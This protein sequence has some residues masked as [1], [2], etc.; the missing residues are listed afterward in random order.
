MINSVEAVGRFQKIVFGITMA[1]LSASVI[2]TLVI[3]VRGLGGRVGPGL[4]VIAVDVLPPPPVS[5]LPAPL[6]P[7]F[8]I[9]LTYPLATSPHAAAEAVLDHTRAHDHTEAQ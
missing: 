8:I 5:A 4:Q 6:P 3:F 9:Q 7:H 2:L 1:L